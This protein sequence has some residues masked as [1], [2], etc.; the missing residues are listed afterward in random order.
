MEDLKGTRNHN[1]ETTPKM[2]M[3][4]QEYAAYVFKRTSRHIPPE[5]PPDYSDNEGGLHDM[6]EAE[7]KRRG[8]YY[9]HSRMDRKTTTAK[10]VPD[11]VIAGP[12]FQTY[13]IE[14]KGAKTKITPEQQGAVDWL[15]KLGHKAAFVRSFSE[16]LS[17]IDPCTNDSTNQQTKP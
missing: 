16:F 3:T 8:W 6:I 4:I 11:F 10:G 14:A 1:R 17:A 15:V 5:T 2:R 12:D 9:I 7:L 13:W